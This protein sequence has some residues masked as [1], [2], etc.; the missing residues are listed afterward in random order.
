M[1]RAFG[2]EG[3]ASEP[4]SDREAY[5]NLPTLSSELPRRGYPRD[6]RQGVADEELLGEDPS[7]DDDDDD[8]DDEDARNDSIPIATAGRLADTPSGGA[9][10]AADPDSLPSKDLR[11]SPPR[12]P[13][14]ES[15]PG[16]QSV[17]GAAS[18]VHQDL[19][20]DARRA[21]QR[22]VSEDGDGGRGR[23]V[24]APTASSAVAAASV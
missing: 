2:D 14:Y 13:P 15:R 1:P 20:A 6:E 24:Y 5:Q 4:S 22:G 12:A 17:N 23:G 16:F 11:D 9:A 7:A 3:A 10:A 21:A 18:A 19:D 8:G